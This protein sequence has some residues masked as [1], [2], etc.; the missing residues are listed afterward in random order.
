MQRRVKDIYEQSLSLFGKLGSVHLHSRFARIT[1]R[2]FSREW[3][4]FY[5]SFPAPNL[6]YEA[7]QNP[8]PLK[9]LALETIASTTFYSPITITKFE[10]SSDFTNYSADKPTNFHEKVEIHLDTSS[11]VDQ[12]ARF[13]TLNNICKLEQLPPALRTEILSFITFHWDDFVVDDLFSQ[14]SLL[15]IKALI[16]SK[17]QFLLIDEKYPKALLDIGT[18]RMFETILFVMCEKWMR[19]LDFSRLVHCLHI[20]IQYLEGNYTPE[21]PSPNFALAFPLYIELS[22]F[23]TDNIPSAC[24]IYDIPYW[25]TTFSPLQP[26]RPLTFKYRRVLFTELFQK[27]QSIKNNPSARFDLDGTSLTKGSILQL[28]KIDM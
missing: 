16:T 12:K 2:K 20:N 7:I 23:R 3:Q 1:D 15:H 27:F 28:R 9:K 14:I 26:L 4:S 22:L 11:L 18:V 6:C 24:P 13:K 17:E 21:F 10:F 19:W 8:L 25:K 5:D